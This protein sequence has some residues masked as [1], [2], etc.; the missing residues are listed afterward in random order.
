MADSTA[1]R[2]MARMRGDGFTPTRMPDEPVSQ[3][4][5]DI[6]DLMRGGSERDIRRERSEHS[7][8]THKAQKAFEARVTKRAEE[9]AERQRGDLNLISAPDR[10][11]LLQQ[12]RTQIQAED[13]ER[14]EA[15]SRRQVGEQVRANTRREN[16]Q[17][18]TAA[19]LERMKKSREQRREENNKRL[20]AS[21]LAQLRADA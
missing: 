21:I 20:V 7:L 17:N 11:V 6:I 9:I 18:S 12:A 19:L 4:T 13:R 14:H 10:A 2:L 16:E 3:T 5:R 8:R 15:E 1:E